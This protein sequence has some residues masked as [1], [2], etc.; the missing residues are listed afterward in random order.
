[1]IRDRSRKT[2]CGYDKV[3]PWDTLAALRRSEKP[4][5]QVLYS[6]SCKG[7]SPAS[8]AERIVALANHPSGGIWFIGVYGALQW[9][10]SRQ[11]ITDDFFDVIAKAKTLLHPVPTVDTHMAAEVVGEPYSG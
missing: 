9:E 11:G 6:T 2:T 8:A 3:D 7:L 1:M 10:P 5:S 4:P